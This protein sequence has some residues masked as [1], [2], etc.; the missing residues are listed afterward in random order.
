[1]Y[2]MDYIID[3]IILYAAPHHILALLKNKILISVCLAMWISIGGWC[4]T[5]FLENTLTISSPVLYV[6]KSKHQ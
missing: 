4:S 6:G 2:I 1:M 3:C 5:Y